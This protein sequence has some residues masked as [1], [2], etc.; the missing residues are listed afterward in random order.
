MD[1]FFTMRRLLVCGF[2]F[3]F[4]FSGCTRISSTDVGSGLIP[5]I[6]GVT[7]L[8]TTFNILTDT[9]D[10]LDSVRVFK[11][12]NHVL[13]IINN[14]PI[15]GK[16]N[17]SLYFEV[18]AN[19]YPF[20]MQGIKDSIIVDSAVLVLSYKS[21]FGDSMQPLKLNVYEINSQLEQFRDY[22]VNYPNAFPISYNPS[23]LGPS[24]NVDIRRLGD[25]VINRFEAAK[26]QIRIKLN[27]SFATRM[28]LGYDTTTA[29]KND[30]TFRTYLKG[31]AVIADPSTPANALLNIN[32]TDTN[33]KLALYYSTKNAA[34]TTRD[35]VVT[36][37]RFSGNTS[38]HANFITRNRTGAEITQHLSA[39]PKSD[40]LVYVQASPGTGVRIRVPGLQSLSNRIIHRA[41]LVI[42]QVPDDNH[43]D[44]DA[45]MN[46]PRYL[47]LSIY[48]SLYHR[49][50]SIP[51]SFAITTSG[52]N[53]SEIGGYLTFKTT[54]GYNQVAAYTFNLARFVQG[55]ATRN[56]TAFNMI[57]TA[58][59]NDSIYYSAPYPNQATQQIYNLTP[60]YSNNIANGRVRLGGGTH[61]RFRMR[62]RVIYSKI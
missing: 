45:A 28:I 29:Y 42:E 51:N 47:L 18:A 7:T 22:A 44:I 41:E 10:D 48:D 38:G 5:P 8:D 30:S 27:K 24:V 60:G 21:A 39:V 43:L 14:D 59:S 1:S 57:L 62:L 50:K 54:Q 33:T 53:T 25:S 55:I 19:N 3:V 49:K 58:P 36:N 15:F 6:D 52:P 46:P 35:T 26:N 11:T 37:F 32:L 17:A 4:I 23:A 16:T 56:D 40:S 31:F 20:L 34:S 9:Y 61:T 2:V 13:G 12:D